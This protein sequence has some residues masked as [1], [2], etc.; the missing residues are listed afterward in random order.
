MIVAPPA[1]AR[2]R[3]LRAATAVSR[4]QALGQ[5]PEGA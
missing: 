2:V 1:E 3:D 5:W 4:G